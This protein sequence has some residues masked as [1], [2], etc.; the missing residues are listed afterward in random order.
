MPNK[1][2][3]LAGSLVLLS[4]LLLIISFPR[5]NLYP[6][7]WIALVPW[8][9][10]LHS[11][12]FKKTVLYSFVLGVI[13]FAGLLSWVGLFGYFPWIL[14]SLFQALFII[15]TG[16][17]VWFCRELSSSWRVLAVA[18]FWTLF[19]FLRGIG[20]YGMTWGW[21]GYSQSPFIPL[22][23]L[24]S[25]TGVLGITFLIVLHNATIAEIFLSK[26]ESALRRFIPL[27]SVWALIVVII[28]YGVSVVNKDTPDNNTLKVTI[29]QSTVREP[30]K[31]DITREWTSDDMDAY[32]QVLLEQMQKATTQN[33]DII[34]LPESALPSIL[35]KEEYLLSAVEKAVVSAKTWVLLGSHFE[36]SQEKVYNS[37]YLF[38]PQGKLSDR[39][40]KLHLVPFSEFVPGRH[41][42]PGLEYYPIRDEDLAAG[43]VIHVLESG[44]AKL[45]ISICF[46]SI[47]P[48]FT[49]EQIRR[50]ANLL[51][52]ITNDA[53]F[54]K[55]A[56][57]EQHRQMAVFRAV[58]NRRW[59]ARGALTGISCFISPAGQIVDE[60][61]LYERGI[62]TRDIALLEDTTFFVENGN[63]FIWLT[64]AFSLVLFI[65]VIAQLKRK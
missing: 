6:L 31:E 39:Y 34:I 54:L 21:L 51:V 62:V 60:L 37:A 15:L 46:E 64:I 30:G 4:A 16:L 25:V 19:E 9:L 44:D 22:I 59:V 11:A 18:C 49:R 45:G 12:D 52:I 40:D 13:F 61:Q 42:L 57:A 38:S 8:I 32:R 53:W 3:I 36:D 24:S 10:V 65:M 20:T 35:N 29:L 28:I 27:V 55:T 1:K 5:F 43:K 17:L 56:A 2:P 26:S 33:P 58:E 47:F 50:G 23:Q 41:M 14:L 48:Q 63:W 7:A